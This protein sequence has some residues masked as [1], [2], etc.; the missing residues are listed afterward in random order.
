MGG[1]IQ[2]SNVRSSGE[3]LVKEACVLEFNENL[4]SENTS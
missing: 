4:R 2:S 3:L 1:A